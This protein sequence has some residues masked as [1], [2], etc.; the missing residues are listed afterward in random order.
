MIVC[1]FDVNNHELSSGFHPGVEQITI[2]SHVGDFFAGDRFP[3]LRVVTL[4]NINDKEIVIESPS[5]RELSVIGYPHDGM[6]KLACA[7]LI[8]LIF[9]SGLMTELELDCPLLQ[10]LSFYGGDLSKL[11]MK[12]PMLRWLCCP[13][14]KLTELDLDCPHLKVLDCR[15]NPLTSLNGLEFCTELRASL[16][17]ASVEKMVRTLTAA[18]LLQ[19]QASFH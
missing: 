12:C 6:M 16:F 3:N 8:G 4:T 11:R 7:S 5:L 19:I 14:N 2:L 13:S 17:P 15:E 9:R 18:H 10:N 1:I